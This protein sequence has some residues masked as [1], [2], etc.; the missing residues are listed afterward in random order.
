MCAKEP[1][2]VSCIIFHKSVYKE[3]ETNCFEQDILGNQ[4]DASSKDVRAYGNQLTKG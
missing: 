3:M 1:Q 4:L 2:R